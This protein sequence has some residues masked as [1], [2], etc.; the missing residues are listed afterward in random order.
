M[1]QVSLTPAQRQR[2]KELFDEAYELAPTAQARWLAA[3]CPDDV[4]VCAEVEK[5]LQ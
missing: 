3:A 1:N 5:L 4:A 2:I